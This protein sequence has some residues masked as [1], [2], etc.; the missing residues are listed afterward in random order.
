MLRLP[1]NFFQLS[2]IFDIDACGCSGFFDM[3][4]GVGRLPELNR[5]GAIGQRVADEAR[6]CRVDHREFGGIGAELAGEPVEHHVVR[7]ALR[8][9]EILALEILAAP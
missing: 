4:R 7:G 3:Q 1:V 5:G 6:R 8:G 2:A 9:R